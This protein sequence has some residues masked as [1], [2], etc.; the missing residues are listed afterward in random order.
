MRKKTAECHSTLNAISLFKLW[1]SLKQFLSGLSPKEQGRTV[2][3]H[4]QK[5]V[6]KAN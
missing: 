4:S 1:A 5:C 3:L 6:E 2:H